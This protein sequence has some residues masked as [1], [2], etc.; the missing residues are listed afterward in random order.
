MSESSRKRRLLVVSDMHLGRDCKEITGFQQTA[1]PDDKFDQAFIDMIDHYTSGRE[2]EWRI[3]FGGDFIDFV[4]VVVVPEAQGPFD[5]LWSFEVTHEEHLF[6]L[7]TEAERSLVKL[8]KTLQYHKK[9]FSRVAAFIRDGGEVVIIRGNHDVE[10]YWRKV[11]RALRRQLA[12]L[13]FAG[14]HLDVDEAIDRRNDFQQRISFSHWVYFEPGRLYVEHGHQYDAYCSFDHQLYPVSPTNPRKVDTPIFMFA[15]RYFVNM[16]SDFAAHNADFWTWRDYVAWLRQ[17]GPAGMLYTSRMGLETGVRMLH[18]AV[19]FARG[20]V[21][22][23]GKEHGKNL[24]EEALRFGLPA[25]RLAQIDALHHTPANRNLSEVMRLLFLDRILLLGG[26][27]TLALFVLGIFDNPWQELFGLLLVG[28]A[29]AQVNKKMA[30]RRFLKPGPKQ[31][32][33]AKR[34][35]DLLDVPLVVMGHSHSWQLADLGGGRRYVNTG[36]WLP[37]LSGRDHADPAEPCSCR[38]SHLVVEDTAELR[39]FCKAAKTVRLADLEVTKPS[40]SD[41]DEAPRVADVPAG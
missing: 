8:D 31:A 39:V 12:D 18:Y 19:Q 38:L 41:D 5:L 1:R 36:C 29:A 24:A 26:A 37:P 13:A 3:V 15:M 4:E 30:P 33:A 10:L 34:I 20:R 16:M 27:L 28:T 25:E 17:K 35:A 2:E 23:Y 32:R 40:T 14:M 11:Q 6:G 9:L 7:G 22:R 21:R